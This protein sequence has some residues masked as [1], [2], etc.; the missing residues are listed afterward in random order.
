MNL[1]FQF[2]IFVLF[3]I[4]NSLLFIFSE[5]KTRVDVASPAGEVI[6]KA[7]F[8]NASD[9]QRYWGTAKNLANLGEFTI[10][11]HGTKKRDAVSMPL[12]RAGP[13]PAV[14]SSQRP[15]QPR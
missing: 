6:E 1:R 14:R 11:I 10:P 15:R 4:I 9:G 13:L 5:E 2:V 3:L 7:T 8:W 12:T